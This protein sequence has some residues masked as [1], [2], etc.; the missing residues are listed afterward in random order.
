MILDRGRIVYRG[1]SAAL[2]ADETTQAQL[3][4]VEAKRK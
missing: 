4:G 3:L 2:R 1:A